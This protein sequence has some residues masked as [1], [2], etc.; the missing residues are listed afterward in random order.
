MK[1]MSTGEEMESLSTSTASPLLYD[2]RD[3]IV[4]ILV[5]GI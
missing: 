4:V 5:N 2:R 1:D 3:G